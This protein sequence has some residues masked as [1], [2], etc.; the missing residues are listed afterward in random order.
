MRFRYLCCRSYPR[1]LEVKLMLFGLTT[2]DSDDYTKI[3]L[4][5]IVLRREIG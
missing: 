1:T 4:L 2:Q 3:E 5:G